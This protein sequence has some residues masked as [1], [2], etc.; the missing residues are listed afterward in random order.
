MKETSVR[1]ADPELAEV[2]DLCLEGALARRQRGE[3]VP[4]V[5]LAGIRRLL[6]ASDPPPGLLDRLQEYLPSIL[7]PER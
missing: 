1:F 5:A 6:G 4:P 7:R 3:A 2:L